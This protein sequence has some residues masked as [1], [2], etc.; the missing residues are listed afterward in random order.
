MVDLQYLTRDHASG[1]DV[2]LVSE[3]PTLIRKISEIFDLADKHRFS[4]AVS[5]PR[6]AAE[7]ARQIRPDLIILDVHFEHGDPLVL[8]KQFK[9]DL[10]GTALLLVSEDADAIL[11]ERAF[12]AGADGFVVRDVLGDDLLPAT[13]ELLHGRCFASETVM[14]D[15]LRGMVEA[16]P[17]SDHL[18]V[19]LLSDREVVVF[20]FLGQGHTIREIATE[21]DVNVKTVATHCKNIRKK[22]HVNS[23]KNLALAGTR[24]LETI[25]KSTTADMES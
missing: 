9:A 6:P 4:V 22:L 18:P 17:E 12:R 23:N 3:D 5:P 11:A 21:L 2:L 14:Q 1:T 7:R 19:D 24:W 16:A 10:P 25:R 8:V 20:R 15:I 13:E